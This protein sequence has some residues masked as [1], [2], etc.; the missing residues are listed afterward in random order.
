MIYSILYIVPK[1]HIRRNH[2]RSVKKIGGAKWCSTCILV[3][4]R[5]EHYKNKNKKKKQEQA[6]P[7]CCTVR[8]GNCPAG[9]S[10]SDSLCE[11][12]L[13][14]SFFPFF[15]LFFLSCIL[16]N[17]ASLKFKSLQY[18]GGREFI[19]FK[20]IFY[21]SRPVFCPD[22]LEIEYLSPAS[23]I[24]SSTSI[25]FIF[26]F[27]LN[28]SWRVLLLQK[29]GRFVTRA[30]QAAHHHVFLSYFTLHI[31]THQGIFFK[32]FFTRWAV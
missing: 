25:R 23:P 29:M 7:G 22:Q 8:P 2:Q 5:W 10:S 14:A 6:R 32:G 1:R 16:R 13:D 27:P 20:F 24:P 3:G 26:L 4:K 30:W 19:G 12:F 15:R 21:C 18:K 11:G 31:T 17:L 28:T 9:G